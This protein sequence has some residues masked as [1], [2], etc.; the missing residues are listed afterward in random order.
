MLDTRPKKE[1]K[2]SKIGGRRKSSPLSSKNGWGKVQER[3]V[4]RDRVGREGGGGM[5]VKEE[6]EWGRQWCDLNSRG[7]P[8]QGRYDAQKE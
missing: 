5:S 2:V 3:G 7:R 6:R 8:P 1:I 4:G